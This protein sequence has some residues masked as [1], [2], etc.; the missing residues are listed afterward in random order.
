MI[1]ELNRRPHE[2]KHGRVLPLNFYKRD[3]TVVARELLGKQLV[4]K[5]GRKRMAG[6]IVETEAYTGIE[7]AAAHS[8]GGRRTPRNESMYLHGGHSYVYFIYGMY[9]CINAV[10][11]EKDC[12]EAVLIRALQPTEG[13]ADM[14]E[15]RQR[16]T[17]IKRVE[18]LTNGPGKL[19][20][21]LDI[22]REQDGLR[23]DSKTLFVEDIGF[24][25]PANQIQIA[26]RIGVDYA[27]HA[28]EWPLRFYIKG[29][30]FVSKM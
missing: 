5:V 11:R 24:T 3:T 2:Y 17:S 10:T 25:P 28:A 19:T 20:Q 1:V 22:D 14:F 7:D 16:R 23:L 12:P 18:N 15:L 27:G 6:I 9:F 26:K 29:N 13:L 30:P 8:F 4:H 21:A